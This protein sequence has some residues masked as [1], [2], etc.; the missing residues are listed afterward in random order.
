[1]TIKEIIAKSKLSPVQLGKSIKSLKSIT[2]SEAEFEVIKKEFIPEAQ[3]ER[4]TQ[5]V[6]GLEQGAQLLLT[7]VSH[8]RCK[9]T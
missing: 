9:E 6:A 8:Q 4:V 1:M 5:I 2:E 7:V 3:L